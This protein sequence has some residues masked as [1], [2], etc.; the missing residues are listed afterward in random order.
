M[1]LTWSGTALAAGEDMDIFR[2]NPAKKIEKLIPPD[3]LKN[4]VTIADGFMPTALYVMIR[5]G[6]WQQILDEPEPEA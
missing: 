3:F 6:K 5:F 1:P 4:H 2:P